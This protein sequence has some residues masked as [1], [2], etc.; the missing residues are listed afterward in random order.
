MI[1]TDRKTNSSND[2]NLDDHDG[3]DDEDSPFSSLCTR[4]GRVGVSDD[5]LAL[6][7]FLRHPALPSVEALTERTAW[8]QNPKLT[9]HPL[10][11]EQN[12]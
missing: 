6:H 5:K 2:N 10:I 4:R 7:S 8:P 1:M 9:P 12:P 11:L 3:D